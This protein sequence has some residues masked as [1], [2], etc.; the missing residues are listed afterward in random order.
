MR[1]RN[2][3]TGIVSTTLKEAV[4]GVGGISR[5]GQESVE[6]GCCGVAGH[7]LVSGGP[8]EVSSHGSTV[9]LR[10]AASCTSSV[11]A[12]PLLAVVPAFIE[13]RVPL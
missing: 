13:I 7:R 8:E 10:L 3:D 4:G 12:S 5:V 9:P 6:I 1:L 11:S 2:I